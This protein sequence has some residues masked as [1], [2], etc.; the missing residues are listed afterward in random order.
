VHLGAMAGTVDLMQ[1]VGTGI[2]AK[3]D[4][5]RINPEIPEELARLDLRIRYR[6]HSLRLRLTHDSLTVRGGDPRVAPIRLCVD[7]RTFE[8]EGGSTRAFRLGDGVSEQ[9]ALRPGGAHPRA[10]DG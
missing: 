6:G 1:R 5:L 2:E 7:D 10:R 9:K 8:F 3:G 4:V